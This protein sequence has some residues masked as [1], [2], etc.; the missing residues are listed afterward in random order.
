MKS[1]K[2]VKKEYDD[3]R[4]EIIKEIEYLPLEK[5]EVKIKKLH[6]LKDEL[7]KIK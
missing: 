1:Y 2:E 5:S 4:A 7:N 3:L 6:E